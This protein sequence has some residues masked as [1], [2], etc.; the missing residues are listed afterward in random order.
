MDIYFC[1]HIIKLKKKNLKKLL[2]Q[3]EIHDPDC[4]FG[5]LIRDAQVNLIYYHLNIKKILF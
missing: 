1:Y 3:V 4:S 2:N 5:R